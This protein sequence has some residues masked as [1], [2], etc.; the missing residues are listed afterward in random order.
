MY[1]W[2]ILNIVRMNIASVSLFILLLLSSCSSPLIITKKNVELYAIT[3]NNKVGYINQKG[4]IV[5]RPI[6]DP[7]CLGSYQGNCCSES[8]FGTEFGV[9][10]KNGKLGAIDYKGNTIVEPKYDFLEQ[11]NDSSFVAGV[12]GK[13][14]IIDTK[15]KIV[16]PFIFDSEYFL[17]P[18]DIA[19]GESEGVFYLLYSKTLTILKTPYESISPFFD[20]FAE[21]KADKKSGYINTLGEIIITPQFEDGGHFNNGLAPVKIGDKWGFIDTTGQTKISPRFDQTYGFD[22]NNYAIVKV[23]DNY[24]V[25][26]K[27]GEFIIQPVYSG[28]FLQTGKVFEACIRDDSSEKCGLLDLQDGWLY[29]PDLKQNVD[30]FDNKYIASSKQTGYG[31]KKL[32]TNKVIVPF[33]FSSLDFFPYGLSKFSYYDA[34]LKKTIYGYLNK[35]GKIVWVENG[36]DKKRIK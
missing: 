4:K 31:V 21:V 9:I 23:G 29:P 24:G 17:R 18:D 35:K 13:W 14:G 15:E 20:G 16:F 7:C 34:T 1:N 19:I 5:L 26:A 3:E 32:S 10:R 8:F 12:D 22:N 28:L 6:F 25:I 36:V 2:P 27:T 11:R 30:Y 33:I